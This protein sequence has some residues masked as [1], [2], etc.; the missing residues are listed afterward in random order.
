MWSWYD[1]AHCKITAIWLM[2][3]STESFYLMTS[4]TFNRF[5]FSIYSMWKPVIQ[6]VN[7]GN[8]LLFWTINWMTRHVRLIALVRRIVLS[9][10][11]CWN[12]A[13]FTSLIIMTHHTIRINFHRHVFM[14]SNKI[15]SFM[16][17]RSQ[18]V[19]CLMA[20]FT[21]IWCN[22]RFVV[23]IRTNFHRRQ[24]I[25]RLKTIINFV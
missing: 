16:I 9:Y 11:C 20:W 13:I 5:V 22:F 12:M 14:R 24:V 7:P 6:I 19:S 23:T 15:S 21:S 25:R 2:T 8:H 17:Y 3:F 4:L 18:V 1:A 10:H